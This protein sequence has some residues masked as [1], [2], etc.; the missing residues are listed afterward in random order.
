M[1]RKL[2][3]NAAQAVAVMPEQPNRTVPV[4]AMTPGDKNEK[5]VKEWKPYAGRDSLPEAK[6]VE[7]VREVKGPDGS[8]VLRKTV[9]SVVAGEPRYFVSTMGELIAVYKKRGGTGR[10]LVH[11]FKRQY[12]DTAEGKA[13]K[14]RDNDFRNFLRSKGIPGA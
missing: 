13:R 2:A 4:D 12:P 5:E 7:K 9:T 1:A 11:Q 8:V 10:R 6:Y 14:K 3:G